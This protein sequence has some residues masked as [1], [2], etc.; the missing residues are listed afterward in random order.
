[1]NRQNEQD[2]AKR[3]KKRAELES[4]LGA[5]SIGSAERIRLRNQLRGINRLQTE[6]LQRAIQRSKGPQQEVFQVRLDA[7]RAREGKKSTPS[8]ASTS[9]PAKATS[10]GRSPTTTPVAFDDSPPVSSVRSPGQTGPRPEVEQTP[11][12]A[13]RGEFDSA[14]RNLVQQVG[15]TPVGQQRTDT[16]SAD[17]VIS[18]RETAGTDWN[19]QFEQTRASVAASQA[20]VLAGLQQGVDATGESIAQSESNVRDAIGEAS[21]QSQQNTRD[22]EFQIGELDRATTEGFAGTTDAVNEAS[23]RAR[24]DARD[25][26]STLTA[27]ANRAAEDNEAILGQIGEQGTYTRDTLRGIDEN[28]RGTQH[29]LRGGASHA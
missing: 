8:T 7:I 22:V 21:R 18:D 28:T 29:G 27:F 12:P 19:T 2:Y 20:D 24:R 1:M 16:A 25:T 26:R 13:T 14:R 4:R 15:N 5:P 10:S 11:R 6:L 17:A 9:S 23:R 3:E